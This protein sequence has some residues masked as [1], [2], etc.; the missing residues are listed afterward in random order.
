M[1]SRLRS[2]AAVLLTAVLA[3]LGV[4]T[5][6]TTA[7]ADPGLCNTQYSGY[8]GS[9]TCSGVPAGEVW[10]AQVGCF[11]I[12][13][14]GVPE[15]FQVVGNQVTGNGTSTGF[16]GYSTYATKNISEVVLS[17]PP[18]SGPT[19]PIK[20]IAGMCLDVQ[21]ANTT[22]ATPVQI[23]GC[24][25][26]GAQQWTVASDGTLHALGKCLDVHNGGTGNGTQVQ[27][28]DCNGS[29]AQQWKPQPNGSVVNPQSGRCLDV[30]NAGT[31]NGTPVQIYDCN[32]SVAQQWTL[33]H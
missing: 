13:S 16:C 26:S 2:S 5:S 24:N 3:L 30:R 17:G 21:G 33:P 27:I 8:V 10:E 18:V 28:Y 31:G 19:G 6:A 20:G 23:Y 4:F 32:G 7:Q 25:G 11:F 9:A 15:S 22:N 1:R 12:D 14:A 29:G